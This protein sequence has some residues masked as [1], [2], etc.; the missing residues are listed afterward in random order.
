MIHNEKRQARAAFSAETRIQRA[1]ARLAESGCPV[2]ILGE[3]GAG[4]RFVAAQ[5]HA[6]SHLSRSAF[7]EIRCFDAEA[8]T[9]QLRY[10]LP[11]SLSC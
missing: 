3:H 2:L 8:S 6:Q 9:L 7:Q 11:Y 10:P 1:M 4:K 5:I